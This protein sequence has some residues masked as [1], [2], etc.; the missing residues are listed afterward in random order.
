MIRVEDNVADLKEHMIKPE[1]SDIITAIQRIAFK[2]ME[3]LQEAYLRTPVI[4]ASRPYIE[5][6]LM[7]VKSL[8]NLVRMYQSNCKYG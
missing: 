8:I 2:M 7:L 4:T 1:C 6:A 3:D 5:R